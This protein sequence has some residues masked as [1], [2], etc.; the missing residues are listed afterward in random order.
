MQA[1]SGERSGV[2][3]PEHGVVREHYEKEAV[4]RRISVHFAIQ[5]KPL[6]TA[7][8]VLAAESFAAN[9]P[10]VVINSDNY[11]PASALR[12]L[13]RRTRPAMV[14]FSREALIARGNVAPGKVSRFGAVEVDNSGALLSMT[15]DVAR[16][17]ES[18]GRA[19]RTSRGWRGF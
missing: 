1:V 11:Y 10:F 13:H 5:E 15:G 2:I 9:E 16:A 4:P 17:A 3:G 7:D 18:T 6:G 8:A 19:G 14:A 12:E